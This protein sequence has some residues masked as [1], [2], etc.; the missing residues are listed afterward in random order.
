M[1]KRGRSLLKRI[2][3][4]TAVAMLITVFNI[5]FMGYATEGQAASAAQNGFG[6]AIGD[7]IEGGYTPIADEGVVVDD[8]YDEELDYGD[9]PYHEFEITYNDGIFDEDPDYPG[10][11]QEDA[12][13]EGLIT[14]TSSDVDVVAPILQKRVYN[15]NTDKYEYIYQNDIQATSKLDVDDEGF[16]TQYFSL[17]YTGFGQATITMTFTYPDGEEVTMAEFPVT[18]KG[19]AV[20]IDQDIFAYDGN[21]KTPEIGVVDWQ[22]NIVSEDNYTLNYADGR[23][24][25]GV[26]DIEIVFNE[27]YDG[28]KGSWVTY[29]VITPKAPASVSTRLTGHDDIRVSWKA[30]T[31]ADGYYVYYKKG[32]GSYNLLKRV[33]GTYATA[34][35]LTDGAKY[36]FKIVPYVDA[37]GEKVKANVYKTSAATYTLKKISTPKV[38]KSGTKVKVRWTNISGETGYQISRSTKSKGTNIVATY[39]TTKGTYKNIT[40]KKGTKYYYKVRAYKS[41]VVNG[42]TVKVYGPWSETKSYRR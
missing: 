12:V 10:V 36:T 18:V 8:L 34:S 26:Y 29:F 7:H 3:M 24:L 20:V 19:V 2:S 41:Y 4:I 35:N 28:Y 1:K 11:D 31:G 37:Y 17:Y 21:V 27:D 40:A 42:K 13:P 14:I 15:E 16:T 9:G 6:V 33:T 22:G 38:S 23:K 25:P 5:P 39:K 32:T 30:S